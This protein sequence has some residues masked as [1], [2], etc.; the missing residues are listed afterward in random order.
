MF[1]RMDQRERWRGVT[2]RAL[3]KQGPVLFV[4]GAGRS[5]MRPTANMKAVLRLIREHGL[6]PS[7]CLVYT[8]PSGKERHRER[9]R[10][11]HELRLPRDEGPDGVEPLFGEGESGTDGSDQ[12]EDEAGVSRTGHL[13]EGDAIAQGIVAGAVLHLPRGQVGIVQQGSTQH[14]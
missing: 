1:R 4:D 6:E 9:R 10:R 2:P 7:L 8:L 12:D 3:S 5:Y 13:V 11:R 14:Q